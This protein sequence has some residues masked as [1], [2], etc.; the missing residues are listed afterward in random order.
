MAAGHLA[1]GRSRGGHGP[2]VLGPRDSPPAAFTLSGH[3]LGPGIGMGQ[4]GAFGYAVDYHEPYSWILQHYYANTTAGV[5]P[6]PLVSVAITGNAGFPIRVTSNTAFTV[7][8]GVSGP[9][10]AT[11]PANTA[12]SM[13]LSDRAAGTWS[14]AT[15]PSCTAKLWQPLSAGV[16]P[17]T[18]PVAVPAVGGPSAT[19]AQV[20]DLCRGDGVVEPLRGEIEGVVHRGAPRT[21]NIVAMNSYLEGVVPSEAIAGWG[22]LGS[23]GP[24]GEPWGFQSLEAQAVAARSYADAFIASGGW[25][26]YASICDSSECQAYGGMSAETPITDLAVTDTG[27]EVRLTST[28]EVADTEYSASS[29]GYTAGGPYPAVPDLGDSVCYGGGTAYASCNPVHSWSATVTTSA[30]EATF[31][32]LGAI[33]AL[34]VTARNGLGAAGGRALSV[35]VV[36]SLSTT[37]LSGSAFAADFSL[38]SDW[39]S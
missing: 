24:D 15:G 27:D 7:R 10:I 33:T 17:T 14:L 3:G 28:G 36:G 9:T 31:P 5:V 34:T 32:S 16:P 8:E 13:T 29:G 4:W 26:G 2:L 21:V 22:L 35:E 37:T 1:Q 30:L 38:D 25:H 18:T 6:N 20:L 12:L 39:L 19:P 11:I 23:P